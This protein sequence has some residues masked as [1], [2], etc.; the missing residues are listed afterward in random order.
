M[1][2]TLA[3]WYA[4][5]PNAPGT[6]LDRLED[7]AP[8][9]APPGPIA[10]LASRLIGRAAHPV[11]AIAF[12]KSPDANWALGWHQDRT[13]NV[14]ARAEVAGYGPWTR[15]QGYLHVQPPF[16]LIAGMVTL[17]I[18]LDSVTPDNAPLEIA[19]GSHRA[20]LIP[21]P[22]VPEVVKASQVFAC[23]AEPG[24]VWAYATPILHASRRSASTG[25]RRVLQVDY[26]ADTLPAPLEWALVRE[27]PAHS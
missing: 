6:R 21:E 18:H 5:T 17:R 15:K 12:D 27:I 1:L 7:F 14:A 22:R 10:D 4:G 19:L 20:G 8:F 25:Q 26:S 3:R 11:R 9:L 23:L 13:I 16:A 2:P 24:D